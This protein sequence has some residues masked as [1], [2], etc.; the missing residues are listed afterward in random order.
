VQQVSDGNAY[1]LELRDGRLEGKDE[2]GT[3]TLSL[4]R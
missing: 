2:S 4:G 3:V 1:L